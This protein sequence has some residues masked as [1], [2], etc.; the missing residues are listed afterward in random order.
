MGYRSVVKLALR[1]QAYYDNKANLLESIKDCDIIS[2][3]DE[4]Y[5]F[6]WEDVK[7]YPSYGDV[8]AVEEVMD[9]LKEEEYGFMRIGEETNDV[10]EKGEPWEYGIYMNR[11]FSQND[12]EDEIDKEEFFKPNSIKFIKEDA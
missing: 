12:E 3:T 1:K 10:E 2:E 9:S 8:K 7:W 11:E 6:L 4:A 5:F